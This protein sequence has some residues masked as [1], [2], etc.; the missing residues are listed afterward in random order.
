M[1]TRVNTLES[2]LQNRKIYRLL[3]RIEQEAGQDLTADEFS[4]F[5]TGYLQ[6]KA[7]RLA[8]AAAAE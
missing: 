1:R 2:T 3:E 5:V 8:A 4:Q 6:E 7:D